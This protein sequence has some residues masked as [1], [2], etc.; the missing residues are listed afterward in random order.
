MDT[1]FTLSPN[2]LSLYLTPL[3][4][5][6]LMK[7]RLG[8]DHRQG[9]TCILGD[10]GLGKSTLLRYLFAEYGAKAEIKAT[11]IPTPDFNSEYAMLKSICQDFGLPPKRSIVAQN[12]TFQAF[13]I[14]CGQGGQNVLVFIDEAQKLTN[15]MLEQVRTMLNFETNTGK[16]VQIVL[17]GQLELKERLLREE[18]AGIKSRIYASSLMEPLL[19]EEMTGMIDY[20]CKLAEIKNPFEK[21]ALKEIFNVTQGIPRDVLKVCDLSYSM[22]VMLDESKVSVDLVLSAYSEGTDALKKVAVG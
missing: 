9:L 5:R 19:Y 14:E 3:I 21:D 12:E 20:R 10:P 11:L 13:L 1:P 16:L 7:C 22:A 6:A 18:N 4:K 8:I 2:P 15:R 17:A